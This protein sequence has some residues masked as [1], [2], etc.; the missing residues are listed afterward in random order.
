M[1]G[2]NRYYVVSSNDSNVYYPV[3]GF[4]RPRRGNFSLNF[5]DGRHIT[6]AENGW[7]TTSEDK[8]HNKNSLYGEV[9]SEKNLPSGECKLADAKKP[10]S[11]MF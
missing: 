9:S 6:I 3:E 7:T 2:S 8:I 11:R 5:Q 4:G 1:D 10:I